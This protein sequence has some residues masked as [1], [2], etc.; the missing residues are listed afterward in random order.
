M[1][2]LDCTQISVVVRC[3]LCPWWS[4]FA[5]SKHEGWAVGARH[6]R[7]AHPELKQAR[8]ARNTHRAR[9]IPVQLD[10]PTNTP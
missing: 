10:T 8:S 7:R 9:A 4:G 1:I 2:S 3:T 5:D 6:E